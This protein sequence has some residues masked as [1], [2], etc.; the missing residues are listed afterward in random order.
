MLCYALHSCQVKYV[1]KKVLN[2]LILSHLKCISCTH[3]LGYSQSEQVSKDLECTATKNLFMIF[4]NFS[5]F[6]INPT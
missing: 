1:L 2:V 5:R 6:L 3:L 4:I